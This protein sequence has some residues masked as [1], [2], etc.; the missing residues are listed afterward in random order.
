MP[1][2]AIAALLLLL[3]ACVQPNGA[4]E[5]AA[6]RA[7][8]AAEVPREPLQAPGGQS[9]LAGE[10][11]VIEPRQREIDEANAN[12]REMRARWARERRERED[13]ERK[14]REAQQRREREGP[15][16][17]PDVAA[18]LKLTRVERDEFEKEAWV[19][20]PVL[21]LPDAEHGW[22][23]RKAQGF[24]RTI[25]KTQEPD[26]HMHQLYIRTRSSLTWPQWSRAA[27]ADGVR[28][29]VIEIDRD[30]EN[31]L[32]HLG[33]QITVIDYTE[34]L[35][36]ELPEDWIRA[37]LQD[38]KR[39]QISS[40]RTNDKLVIDL[41]AHYIQAHLQAVEN[42]KAGKPVGAGAEADK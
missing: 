7:T 13:R 25:F 30:T 42:A 11:E 36:V 40:N 24:L 2:I 19:L 23:G 39:F 16:L 38:P 15:P 5:V 17:L 3:A 29:H 22:S 9:S 18:V 28:L 21:A 8:P 4:E 20:G 12:Y 41:P 35:A 26:R 27:D 14:E 32:A 33:S 34:D 31:A 6:M 1:R 37:R 10:L